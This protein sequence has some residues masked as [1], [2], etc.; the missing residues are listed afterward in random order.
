MKKRIILVLLLIIITFSAFSD[1]IRGEVSS[2]IA[3]NSEKSNTDFKLYNLIGLELEASP[4]INGLELVLTIPEELNRYR[5]SFM[6][7][8]YHKLDRSP[9]ESEKNYRAEPLLTSILPGTTKMFI[10]IPIEEISNTELLPGSIITDK[11]DKADFPL[12]FSI[13]PVMKGI[14]NSVLSSI[15]NLE[16]RPIL[17]NKGIL[18]LDISGQTNG[19]KITILLNGKKTALKNE[20][21]L[22]VGIHQIIV[23]SNHFKEISESFVINRA[24]E[25]Q[26]NLKMEQILS[27][28]I[29]EAP[30]GSEIILDGNKISSSSG[31]E[32]QIKPGEHVVRIELEDYHLS[33]KFTIEP[34]KNYKISLFLDILVQDN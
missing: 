11:I 31:D 6:L 18:K 24:E 25:T 32:L 17:N 1:T 10:T 22:D 7:N 21:S 8:I 29:F 19:N 30:R 5:D 23:L 4:F 26:L 12:L 13:T 9:V 15:F 28:V 33:K 27:T 34:E 3:I 14:P 16:L 2:I 20:Y